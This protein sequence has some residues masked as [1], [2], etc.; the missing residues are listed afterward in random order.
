MHEGGV[1]VPGIIEWPARIPKPRVSKVNSVTSDMLPTLCE[2]AGR[3]LPNRYKL[4]AGA[5][6]KNKSAIELFDLTNDP[7]EEHNLIE[8]RKEIARKMEKPLRDW[9][10]SVL[11]SLTGADYR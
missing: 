11:E 5:Q 9:Q 10:Q 3:P 6:P 2:L 7:A 8:S 1:R 4:V